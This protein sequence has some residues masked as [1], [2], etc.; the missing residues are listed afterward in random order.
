MIASTGTNLGGGQ[1]YLSIFVAAHA[2]FVLLLLLKQS[3]D[4]TVSS[5]GGLKDVAI[6][7]YAGHKSCASIII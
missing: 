7:S 2:G 3:G 5:A 6:P 1:E 4:R